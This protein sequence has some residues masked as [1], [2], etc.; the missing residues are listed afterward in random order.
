MSPNRLCFDLDPPSTDPLPLCAP[1]PIPEILVH[2]PQETQSKVAGRVNKRSVP[3]LSSRSLF[4]PYQAVCLGT[5][6]EQRCSLLLEFLSTFEVSAR[7][8]GSRTGSTREANKAEYA[9]TSR[10]HLTRP[11]LVSLSCRLPPLGSM[12]QRRTIVIEQSK[13]AVGDIAS[14]KESGQGMAP[15]VIAPSSPV[16][17]SSGWQRPTIGSTQTGA[18]LVTP[19]N[20]EDGSGAKMLAMVSPS[21]RTSKAKHGLD[22]EGKRND[23]RGGATQNYCHRWS[24][25]AR[26]GGCGYCVRH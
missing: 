1:P 22:F 14:N 9:S 17:D 19:D 5:L 6:L 10:N 2:R 24:C 20:N 3:S 11:A 15:D 23:E 25:V 12:E 7:Y 21:R 18:R 26:A 16:A 8:L 4:A 13:L